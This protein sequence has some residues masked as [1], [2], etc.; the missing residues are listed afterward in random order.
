MTVASV[1]Q[2]IISF[3][4]FA[5]IARG[6]G[7]EDTG[8]YFFALS[9]TTI[10]VVFVDVGLTNVLVREGAKLKERLSEYVSSIL[11][12]KIFLSILTYTAMAGTLV[13]L[14]YE[15]DT[16]TLVLIA[17]VTMLFDSLHA[18]MYG[19]LRA[20]G[21]ITY[22]AFGI[23]ASQ[24]L[25]LTLGTIFLFTDLPLYFLMIAF[26]VPSVLN[27]L[28]S[29]YIVRVKYG[30]HLKPVYSKEM[31]WY[32]IPITIPFALAMI[33]GRIFSYADS[34]ILS[35][36]AG[37]TAVG[38]YSVP[39]KIAF[40][41]QF[42]PFALVAGLYP[43][44]SEYFIHDRSRLNEI[45]NQGVRYLLIV[46]IPLSAG[47]IFLGTDLIHT[48]FGTQYAESVLPLKILIVSIVAAFMNIVLGA[49]LNAVGRQKTQT[50]LIGLVMCLNIALN[51]FL[52]PRFG[53]V[54]AALAATI[55]NYVLLAISWNVARQIV[56]IDYRRIFGTIGKLILA[57]AS[58]YLV[59]WYTDSSL[60]VAL[61]ALIGAGVF[62]IVFLL[63]R[64]F[65]RADK[66]YF[67]SLIHTKHE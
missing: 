55:G 44:M 17:G 51:I 9:F 37:D 14:G 67:R 27:V 47:I 61:R 39:Y 65:D 46:S 43:R 13:L 48:F 41:F 5:I 1:A 59:L 40:A 64:G 54:G 62:G 63:F 58:M 8:K 38:W 56:T 31:I 25:T 21:N 29:S 45:F 35:K 36:M 32:L 15:V 18:T 20:I 3:V 30:I 7:A 24:L 60:P 49:L 53:V 19:V 28:F 2:K 23:V 12:L 22:E 10:F 34:V 57:C 26:L 6:V 33:F 66:E 16:Q 50:I 4:Y 11:F 52:I 42:T